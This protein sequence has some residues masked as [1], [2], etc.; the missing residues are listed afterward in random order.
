M[1]PVS[2]KYI[3][4]HLKTQ[5]NPLFLHG[6]KKE[7]KKKSQLPVLSGTFNKGCC[8]TFSHPLRNQVWV[9]VF[10]TVITNLQTF[11]PSHLGNSPQSV[12]NRCSVAVID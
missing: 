11:T 2:L 8:K 3:F 4:L 5:D 10:E 6:R 7:R 9:L 1:N 12:K